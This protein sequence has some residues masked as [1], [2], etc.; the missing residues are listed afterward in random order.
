MTD[1]L[2]SRRAERQRLIERAR[3]YALAVSERLPVKAV[4][5]AGSVARGDFNVWSDIDV[6]VVADDLP[7]RLLDRLGLLSADAPAGVQVV[8]YTPAE[9]RRAAL[10]SNRL[11]LDAAAGGILLAGDACVFETIRRDAG[12]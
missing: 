8:G 1:V 10:R 9:L 2:T 5:L 4:V 3:G 6:V 12:P 7:T 11:V